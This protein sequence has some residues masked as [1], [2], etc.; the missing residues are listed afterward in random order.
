MVI[1]SH[2]MVETVRAYAVEVNKYKSIL[3]IEDISSWVV[4]EISN[5]FHAGQ[6]E[7]LSFSEEEIGLVE[8]DIDIGDDSVAVSLHETKMALYK[9]AMRSYKNWAV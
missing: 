7:T 5:F 9:K 4:H 8:N 3:V 2:Q 1:S 6:V